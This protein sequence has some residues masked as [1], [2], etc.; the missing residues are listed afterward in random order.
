MIPR[1]ND[2][3]LRVAA[4]RRIRVEALKLETPGFRLRESLAAIRPGGRLERALRRGARTNPLRLLCGIRRAKSPQSVRDAGPDP[5]ALARLFDAGGAAALAVSTEPERDGGDL[6]WVGAVRAA[7]ALP[8]LLDDVVVDEYQVL[9]AAVRGA[10]GVLLIAALHSDVQ[11]QVLTSRTRLL[12]MDPLV[13]VRDETDL[14]RALKAG[15][16]LVGLGSREPDAAMDARAAA[17]ALLPQ[18]PPLVT[19]VAWSDGWEPVDL[20]RLRGTRCDAVL[21]GEG[22][23]ANPDPA[24]AL[25]A[26]ASAAR[27]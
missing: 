15:T 14:K 17:L 22:L 6:A 21:A 19:A 3:L 26:L 16:T 7:C 20:E 1:A 24:G 25:A 10:D 18:V 11:L 4:A 27:G 8:V 12:G 5:V 9:D 23:V 2:S 13:E